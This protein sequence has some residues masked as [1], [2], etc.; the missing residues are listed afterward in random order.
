MQVGIKIINKEKGNAPLHT[1]L[2][3]RFIRRNKAATQ[4]SMHLMRAVDAHAL[5]CGVTR[6]LEH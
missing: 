4:G 6:A 2:S 3:P 1:S 5:F